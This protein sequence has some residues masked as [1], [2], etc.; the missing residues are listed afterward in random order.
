MGMFSDKN[1]DGLSIGQVALLRLLKASMVGQLVLLAMTTILAGS[2]VAAV[3]NHLQIAL[4]LGLATLIGVTT[5]WYSIVKMAG[6]TPEKII[7]IVPIAQ[8]VVFILAVFSLVLFFFAVLL[9]TWIAWPL[10]ISGVIGGAYEQW[11]AAFFSPAK[12]LRW[13]QTKE[14]KTRS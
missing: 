9:P 12:I 6:Y 14:K 8:F 5:I 1:W 13:E 2:C 7:K 11:T 4:P 3:I 10:I